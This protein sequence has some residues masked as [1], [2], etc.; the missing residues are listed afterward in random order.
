M[1]GPA[2]VSG[3][4][5]VSC[6]LFP[7]TDTFGQGLG[8]FVGVRLLPR[9]LSPSPAPNRGSRSWPAVA[10]LSCRSHKTGAESPTTLCLSTDTKRG[11]MATLLLPSPARNQPGSSSR[12]ER[13]ALSKPVLWH[14]GGVRSFYLTVQLRKFSH[15]AGMKTCIYSKSKYSIQHGHF[16]YSPRII[17][18]DLL[19]IW[20]TYRF[21]IQRMSYTFHKLSCPY[22]PSNTK[23]F[24]YT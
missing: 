3:A 6:Q 15:E 9:T 19:P 22:I 12:A 8:C 10:P 18:S 4:L 1:P 20:K 14:R 16:F 7:G 21:S 13:E 23:S 11:L 17:I 5:P 24:T 2:E